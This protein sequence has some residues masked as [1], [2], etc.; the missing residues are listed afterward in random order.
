[1]YLLIIFV[2][3]IPKLIHYFGH[4][5]YVADLILG[6]AGD[7]INLEHELLEGQMR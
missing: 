5:H 2:V 1:M 3:T 7:T 4:R 6:L